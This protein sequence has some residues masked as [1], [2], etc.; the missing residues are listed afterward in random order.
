MLRTWL[1]RILRGA[2]AGLLVGGVLGGAE[3][4]I[5]LRGPITEMVNALQRL[6]LWGLN[7]LVCGAIGAALGLVLSAAIGSVAGNDSATRSLAAET[8][9]DPRHPW[10]PWV[11]GP[12]LTGVLLVQ[13]LPWLLSG[14]PG[15][16]GRA[17][18][19][20]CLLVVAGAAFAVFLRL[21]LK[22]VDHTGRGGG[23]AVLGLPVLLV[24]TMSL[25]V[26]ASMAGGKG[27]ATR[28]REGTPNVLLI[29]VDGLRADHVGPQARVR[30]ES[31]G[32]LAKKGVR[33]EQATTAS[34]A[35]GP[36]VAALLTGRHPLAS[37]F[38]ADGQG[39]PARV[40]ATGKELKTLAQEFGE[41]GYATGAFVSSAA[42]D[43]RETDLSRGFGVYDDG[44]GSHR[45]G[46]DRLAVPTLLALI[47]SEDSRPIPGTDVLRPSA[48]TLMRFEYWLAYHYRENFFAWVHLADPRVPFLDAPQDTSDL[49]DPLPGDAGRAHGARVVLLDEILGEL[50]RALE[51][52]GLL[53]WTLIVVAGSRG[54]VPGGRPTVDD[55]WLRVPV[56]LYGPGLDGGGEV[57]AP[58]RLHDL[59][60]TILS[61][62]G[63]RRARMGDGESLI[64]LLEGRTVE[65]VQ[66]LSV[67]PPRRDGKCAVSVRTPDWKYVRQPSGRQAWYDLV[68]DP[69]EL[70]DIG[71]VASD[72]M[73]DVAAGLTETL[74][75]EVPV[76][77]VPELG[78]LREAHLR[79]L[80][81]VR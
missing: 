33:F 29:T 77:T 3:T 79:T 40:P 60:P 39:L 71:D 42:L 49:L 14:R 55:A 10:L 56:V 41:E 53:D 32:W 35:D 21:W 30:A 66:A 28:A 1:F 58:V 47:R 24:A 20:V 18:I 45:P 62:A 16:S 7:A 63:F 68:L 9:R 23:V 78:P 38:L 43:G 8:R 13:T 6:Q 65:P 19:A 22:R 72:R 80:D 52:D 48:L 54:Y 25:S 36:S 5:A 64:P 4:A 70:E 46:Y 51:E 15:S 34:T 12:V 44:V 37:G 81:T 11:L 26:S 31:L 2:A 27:G 57:D 73:T 75:R 50:F 59:A 74:G 69:R 61:A 17:A 76:A 67:G